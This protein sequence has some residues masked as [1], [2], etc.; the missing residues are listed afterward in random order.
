MKI[1]L[2][3]LSA[4]L[5]SSCTA[6]K[7]EQWY[8]GNTHTHSLWSDGDDF[9]EMIVGWYKER[10]YDFVALSDHNIL[11]VSE[12]W[13]SLDEIKERQL[14]DELDA[15]VK[16]RQ[17]INGLGAFEKYQ[18][19][20]DNSWIETRENE[21][22]TE[23]RLKKLNEF[24]TLFEEPGKFLI[25]QAEEI[26]NKSQDKPVHINAINIPGETVL[27]WVSS[28]ASVQEVMRENLRAVAELEKKTGQPILA[29]LN[30][31]NFRWAITAEDLAHVVEEQF[32]E[33]YNG[34]PGVNHLGDADHPGDQ[35]I[36]DI[37]NTIR[38]AE[39]DAAP[40]YGVAT[41]DSHTYHG[42]EKSPG[43]GWIMV[44]AEELDG[45]AIVEAMR[46]G[47]FYS[48]TGVVVNA[49]D[50]NSGNNTLS[51][52]IDA[53][54]GILYSTQLIGTRKGYDP[55]VSDGT[56][57]GEVFA[58]QTGTTVSFDIPS[59]ALYA[60]ATITSTKSHP[61]PSYDNQMEQAWIQPVGWR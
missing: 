39:L 16:E 24:R 40:L 31:P 50:F 4:L 14:D 33:V 42:G 54:E 35:L 19:K 18:I 5:V 1:F 52:E 7:E 58:E 48:S 29:H 32:F 44:R 21:G 28:D 57:I 26:S 10:G 56:G 43:R 22:L 60:R 61:N 47:N 49:I 53:E 30:H 6:P 15:F 41:D 51:V 8:K 12:K 25:L 46:A 3:L 9:P 20:Y 34:H 13:M 2:L 17:L 37:A 55:S 11:A 36:W 23:V 59:D 45:N 38:L 27:P